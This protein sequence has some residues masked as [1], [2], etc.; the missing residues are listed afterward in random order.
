MVRDYE[1]KRGHPERSEYT[2]VK[3]EFY[4]G[5]ESYLSQLEYNPNNI[6]SLEDIVRYNKEHAKSEGGYPGVH[7]AWPSGQDS[8]EMSMESKGV[9]ND[10]YHKAVAYVY[11]KSRDEGI[12]AA[13][14]EEDGSMLDGLLVPIQA[15]GSLSCQVA[16]KAGELFTQFRLRV[17]TINSSSNS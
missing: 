3:T 15:D 14:S 11:L 16:A 1:S 2:V 13:L 8:L 5:L 9:M 17:G 10:T 12:D 7:P 4:N 6:K